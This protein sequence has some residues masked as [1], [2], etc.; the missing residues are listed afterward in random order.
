MSSPEE[1]ALFWN[2]FIRAAEAEPTEPRSL[3]GAS[4]LHHPVVALGVDD[5]KKRLIVVSSDPDG[6]S[7]A[8][9]QSDIQASLQDY[10][11]V[12]ARPIA[13][14]LS[15]V[16]GGL[17]D[18]LGK[19]EIGQSDLHRIS[20][21]QNQSEVQKQLMERRMK[22]LLEVGFLPALQ[23]LSY[24]SLNAAAAWQDVIMQLSHLELVPA[25]EDD[26][27]QQQPEDGST[28]IPTIRFGSLKALDPA[29]LDR[30]MGICSV[31]LYEFREDEV[32]L[33]HSGVDIDAAR[34]ILRH[35]NVLQ[36]FFPPPDHVALG[37][38]ETGPLTPDALIEQ[39][40]RSPEIGHPLGP[41][42]LVSTAIGLHDLVDAL[43]ERGLSVEGEVGIE[44]TDDGTRT[45]ASVRFSPRE[46][47][48]SKLS[49]IVS[50]KIDISLRDL[51]GQ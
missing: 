39:V 32:E 13:I 43:G 4:G 44:L 42:E 1:R 50:V 29:E 11:V 37:L 47:F 18:L 30:Q 34:E 33:F 49:K 15:K 12:S 25:G 40:S 27:I 2:S 23:A 9:A 46:G 24:A 5:S 19:A 35:H 38:I 26:V 14:N 45:R 7:A 31:P 36:Y 48:L 3:I 21:L 51:L 22:K 8:L 10:Q 20:E 28:P 17:V 6:R 16:A 41:P